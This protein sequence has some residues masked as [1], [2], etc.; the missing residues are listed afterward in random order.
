MSRQDIENTK[1]KKEVLDGIRKSALNDVKNYGR[2]KGVKEMIER[3]IAATKPHVNWRKEVKH[4]VKKATM[5]TKRKLDKRT[6]Q[7]KSY[8]QVTRDYS[9]ESLNGIAIALDVSASMSSDVLSKMCGDIHTICK[10]IVM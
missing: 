3:I 4:I 7:P 9:A 6:V 2:G 5:A 1:S 8:T 10:G